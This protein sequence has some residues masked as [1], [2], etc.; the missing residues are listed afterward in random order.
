M[1][2]YL[3][4]L[5]LSLTLWCVLGSLFELEYALHVPKFKCIYRNASAATSKLYCVHSFRRCCCIGHRHSIYS[6]SLSLSSFLFSCLH[7]QCVK[8]LLQ[9]TTVKLSLDLFCMISFDS[10][11][12]KIAAKRLCLTSLLTCYS[13][14]YTSSVCC[15]F[16]PFRSLSMSYTSRW[17]VNGWT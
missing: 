1:C 9:T 7:V 11:K 8:N 16:I 5:L 4:Y 14:V 2:S 12:M 17:E 10:F 6:A 3:F 13:K 15:C